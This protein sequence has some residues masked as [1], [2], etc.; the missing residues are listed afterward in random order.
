MAT[1]DVLTRHQGQRDPVFGG[2]QRQWSKHVPTARALLM[3]A[4]SR[5]AAAVHM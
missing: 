1:A 5:S 3:L 2:A 4:A